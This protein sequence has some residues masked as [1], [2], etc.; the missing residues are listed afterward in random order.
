M[1][2]HVHAE[3]GLNWLGPADLGLKEQ[4]WHLGAHE[5]EA[6]GVDCAHK[7]IEDEGVPT[8]VLLVDEGIDGVANHT[9]VQHIAQI[10]A[11]LKQ[12]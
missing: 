10:P 9:W 3:A 12:L 8:C 7:G 6:K 11:G 2:S 4:G 1:T 5:D